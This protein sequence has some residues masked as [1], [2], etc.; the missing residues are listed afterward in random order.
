M[1]DFHRNFTLSSKPKKI[2]SFRLL[3]TSVSTDDS[4]AMSVPLWRFLDFI[5]THRFDLIAVFLSDGYGR[6]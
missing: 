3:A 6:P 2:P 4:S 5:T 1:P